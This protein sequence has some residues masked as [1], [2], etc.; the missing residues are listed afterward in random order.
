MTKEFRLSDDS[1]I[2]QKYPEEFEDDRI[3]V[4]DD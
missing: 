4:I 1:E 3:A 2:C